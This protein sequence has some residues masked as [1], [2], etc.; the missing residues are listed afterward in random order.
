VLNLNSRVNNKVRSSVYAYECVP[1]IENLSLDFTY[2][3]CSRERAQVKIL[4][5]TIIKVDN[6]TE[7]SASRQVVL[8]SSFFFEARL[9]TA[10]SGEKKIEFL[11]GLLAHCC[12]CIVDF[13]STRFVFTQCL[14]FRFVDTILGWQDL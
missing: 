14:V 2:S 13:V 10:A 1:L 6:F 3:I 12:W 7:N 5:R 4:V 9:E 8:T 11:L